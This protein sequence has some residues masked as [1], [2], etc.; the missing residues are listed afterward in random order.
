MKKRLHHNQ[1]NKNKKTSEEISSTGEETVTSLE[2]W[3]IAF[4]KQEQDY[5]KNFKLLEIKIWGQEF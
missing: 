5:E 2:K 4:M 3:K 1:E